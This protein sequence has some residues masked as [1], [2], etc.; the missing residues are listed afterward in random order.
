MGSLWLGTLRTSFTEGR[1][2][3]SIQAYGTVHFKSLNKPALVQESLKHG[4]HGGHIYVFWLQGDLVKILWHH[5]VAHIAL[6]Q[7]PDFS[8][9]ITAVRPVNSARLH[10]SKA[11][12]F[13]KK[14][15]AGSAA[16]KL[17]GLSASAR[18]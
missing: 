8:T 18:R 7:A 14:V 6:C 5:E 11:G 17:Y 10:S 2:I 13:S 15:G 16:P 3:S 12:K 4:P 1:F 9:V